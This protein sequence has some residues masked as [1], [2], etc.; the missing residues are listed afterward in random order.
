MDSGFGQCHHGLGQAWYVS[1][2]FVAVTRHPD[3]KSLR[4]KGSF[5]LW[6]QRVRVHCGRDN[7]AVG[8][9]N[10]LIVL[11]SHAENRK[12]GKCCQA[13]KSQSLPPMTYFPQEAPAHMCSVA[14]PN[15]TASWGSCV[16]R[17]ELMWDI[18]C[19][20]YNTGCPRRGV[21]LAG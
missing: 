4:E 15:S 9:E 11:S 13:T 7:M 2:F 16:Q 5:G 6:F 17:R 3:R 8:T 10:W 20:N 14:F 1:F 21:S 12:R 18:S 19:S